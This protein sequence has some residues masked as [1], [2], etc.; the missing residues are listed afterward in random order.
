MSMACPQWVV[1][2]DL[3][4]HEEDWLKRA[5]ETQRTLGSSMPTHACRMK[6]P[7]IFQAS[8]IQSISFILT[9]QRPTHQRIHSTDLG[10]ISKMVEAALSGPELSEANQAMGSR[11]VST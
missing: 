10:P 7:V 8:Y 9:K 4:I 1:G 11:H 6:L 5:L 3:R 2:A